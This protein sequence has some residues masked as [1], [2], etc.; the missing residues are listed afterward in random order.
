MNKRYPILEFDDHVPAMIEP[1]RVHTPHGDMPE[2]CVICFFHNVIAHLLEEGKLTEIACMHSEM[3]RHPIYRIEG[4]EPTMALLHPGIGAPLA[5]GFLE[6]AIA[7]GGRKFIA[8]GGAGTLEAAHEVGKLIVPTAAIRDEGTSYHYL[9]PGREV[10]PTPSALEA[11]RATLTDAG[12]P[13]ELTKTWTTDAIYRETKTKVQM[14]REDGC[15]VVEMEAAALFAVAQFR[16]VELA[17]ILY[18]GDDLSGEHWD[19][20]NWVSKWEVRAE[21]LKLAAAAC[22]KL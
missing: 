15:G 8:C 10:A 5:A 20:R 6:E 11:I 12:V 19:S 17:Q 2:H 4:Q 1:S 18:A 14:R 22:S 9:P 13:F 7:M 21:L 16:N 3:G